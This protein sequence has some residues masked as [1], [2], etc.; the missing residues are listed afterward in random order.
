M[1]VRSA[2]TC[3]GQVADGYAFQQTK[4][5][6]TNFCNAIVTNMT[7]YA[8]HTLAYYGHVTSRFG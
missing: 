1:I 7:A 2:I 4:P 3:K 8:G 6:G 5:K